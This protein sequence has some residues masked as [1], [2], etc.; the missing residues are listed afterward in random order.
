MSDW[1]TCGRCGRDATPDEMRTALVPDVP[2]GWEHA[3][4]E[5][6]KVVVCP[7][8]QPA[9]W[10]PNCTSLI[11]SDGAVVF[12]EACEAMGEDEWLGELEY[13][14]WID[15]SVTGYEPL[16]LIEWTCPDCGGSEFEWVHDYRGLVPGDRWG[17]RSDEVEGRDVAR[18]RHLLLGLLEQIERVD[19][20]TRCEPLK[21]SKRH[22]ALAAFEPAEIG[23]VDA[24]MMSEF[25]LRE[26]AL[27]TMGA[28]VASDAALQ[29]AFHDPS[30]L[31][32]A[33]CRST[34]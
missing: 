30:R 19:A 10:H 23:A 2:G 26:T 4:V 6:V 22:V 17:R 12:R 7:G 31:R 28:Q 5:D 20:D 25:F 1:R 33:T 16:P 14:G 24:E 34:D 18:S 9:A 32:P 13:C 29:V 27:L 21:R 11:D 15:L 3:Y 8:C